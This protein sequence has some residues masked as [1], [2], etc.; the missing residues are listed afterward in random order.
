[1]SE[2][3]AVRIATDARLLKRGCESL[4][5]IAA[6][7]IADGELNEREIQ[8]LSTWLSENPEV[9]ETWPGKVVSKRIKE[10]LSDGRISDDERAYLVGTL[11]QLIGGSFSDDGVIAS[12]AT[13]LPVDEEADVRIEDESFC[14]TGKFLFGTRSACERAVEARHGR[15]CPVKRGLSY[16]VIG[17]LTSPDWKY[18]SFGHK[19]EAAIKLKESGFAVKI[20][21]E[22]Q[23]V[24]AL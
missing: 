2:Y 23:W 7:L 24:A 20:V 21:S 19:I 18:S 14:F 11:T 4:L 13:A 22:A 8:F 1:M 6:G 9:A 17:E 3:A 5:G 15:V 10:V 12:S 16:L